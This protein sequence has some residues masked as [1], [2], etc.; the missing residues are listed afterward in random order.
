M[1]SENT[2]FDQSLKIYEPMLA[3]Y[4][5]QWLARGNSES[6]NGLYITSRADFKRDLVGYGS[7]WEECFQDLQKQ[8]QD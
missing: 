7:T 5:Y 3:K 6:S 4:G 1:T 2:E 8:L